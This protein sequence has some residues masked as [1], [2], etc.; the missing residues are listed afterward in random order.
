MNT[1]K[2]LRFEIW[3]DGYHDMCSIRAEVSDESPGLRWLWFVFTADEFREL[4]G[5]RGST[6][7]D[8]YHKLSTVGESWTFY[9]LEMPSKSSGI[10]SVPYLRVNFPRTF[11]RAVLRLVRKTWKSQRAAL[12]NGIDSRDIPRVYL[13]VSAKHREKS[14]RLYGNGLGNVNVEYDDPTTAEWLSRCEKEGGETF[15]RM[16]ERVKTIARNTTYGFH[17][18]ATVRISK[19][20]RSWDDGFRWVAIS[21]RGSR[22]MDGGL[23]NHGGRENQPAHAWSIHT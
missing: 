19:D 23:I 8:G 6:A 3:V 1:L 14:A 17:Q 5:G 2:S 21:P 18:T 15:N 13:E 7:S 10:M 16:W 11:M 20:G 12:K 9:D 22:V 4:V